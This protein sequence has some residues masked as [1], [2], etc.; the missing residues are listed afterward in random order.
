[1]I[2]CYR[3]HGFAH[4]ANEI[5]CNN[6]LVCRDQTVSCLTWNILCGDDCRDATDEKRSSRVD[7]N[8]S[9]IWVRRPQGRTPQHVLR[10]HVRRKRKRAQHFGYTVWA[11]GA[12]AKYVAKTCVLFDSAHLDALRTSTTASTAAKMRPYPVQRQMLPEIDSL[13]CNSVGSGFL[14]SR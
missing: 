2:G 9:G 4:V 8:D 5:G 12:R 13:I 3:C 7:R 10:P 6:W 11:K 1:M 14:S